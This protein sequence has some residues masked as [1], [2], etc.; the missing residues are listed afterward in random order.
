MTDRIRHSMLDRMGSLGQHNRHDG[1]AVVGGDS[2]DAAVVSGG[3]DDAAVVSG[4]S[5]DAAVVSG[6]SDDAAVVS[7]DNDD[8]RVLY[9]RANYRPTRK[10][11][12]QVSQTCHLLKCQMGCPSRSDTFSFSVKST[13]RLRTEAVSTDGGG[14]GLYTR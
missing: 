13:R 10:C 12:R 5:D 8:A 14:T 3:N 7:G 9:R 6:G 2:D 4:G 11:H 1:V